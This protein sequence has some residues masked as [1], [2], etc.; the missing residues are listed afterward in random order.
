MCRTLGLHQASP[1]ESGPEDTGVEG[2]AKGGE[3]GRSSMDSRL[4]FWG[5]YILDKGLSLRMGRASVLQDYDIS[6]TFSAEW[7]RGPFPTG[8]VL[9]L[10][11]RHSRIQGNIYEHLYSPAALAQPQDRRVERVNAIV[12]EV[13]HAFSETHE[14]LRRMQE[15]QAEDG[16]QEASEGGAGAHQQHQQNQQQK[17]NPS[18]TAQQ[19]TR[20]KPSPGERQIYADILQS[21][22]VS[23]LSSLTLA[24]RAL[25]P[26]GSRSRT[27]ANEC[28]DAARETIRCHLETMEYVEDRALKISHLHW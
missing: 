1:A 4:L 5:T 28:I 21:D 17:R 9:N 20:R 8:E 26:M 11:I 10:W 7:E 27:F 6:Q 2:E 19:R 14:L 23:Y 16:G 13:N 12:A 22:K 24:Y 18:T 15:S 3:E 25:P